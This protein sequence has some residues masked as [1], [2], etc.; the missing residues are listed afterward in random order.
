MNYFVNIGPE[1]LFW[2]YNKTK[3]HNI[4]IYSVVLFYYIAKTT[5]Y[6]YIL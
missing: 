5:L 1:I 2:Q 6:I 4:Y 3:Q